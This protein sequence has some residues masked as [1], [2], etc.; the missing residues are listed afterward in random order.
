MHE[1][2]QL[3]AQEGCTCLAVGHVGDKENELAEWLVENTARLEM[4]HRSLDGLQRG[5]SIPDHAEVIIPGI[6]ETRMTFLSSFGTYLARISREFRPD[7][8]F[9]QLH[10][11]EQV[12]RAGLDVNALVFHMV[13]DMSNPDNFTVF[14]GSDLSRGSFSTIANSRYVQMQLQSEYGIESR[15]VYPPINYARF[16]KAADSRG[17]EILMFNPVAEKGKDTIRYLIE[18]LPNERFLLVEGWSSLKPT[19]WTY[20]NVSI[21]RRTENVTQLFRRSKILLAPSQWPEA[22]GRVVAEAQSAGVP[23]L[24]SAQAGLIES[25]G[26]KQCLVEDYR[27]PQSWLTKLEALLSSDSVLEAARQHGL[28]HSK[29]FDTTLHLKSL[30]SVLT[31]Q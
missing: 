19:E 20:D 26:S 3:L 25:V 7:I 18:H 4:H 16:N 1:S 14:Q 24:A 12:I 23:V 13:R 6:Y 17:S 11:S 8:V 15:V 10:G 30:L 21:V 22:F 28:E 2:L 27:S 31:G 29:K 9:S 5:N